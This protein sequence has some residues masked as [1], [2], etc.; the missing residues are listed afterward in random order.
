MFSNEKKNTTYQNS[1]VATKVALERFTLFNAYIRNRRK[2]LTQLLKKLE[3]NKSK[4]N[5]K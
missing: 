1:W 2:T 5:P 3:K 4:L